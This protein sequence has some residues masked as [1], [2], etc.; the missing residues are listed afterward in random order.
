MLRLLL[1][2]CLIAADRHCGSRQGPLIARSGCGGWRLNNNIFMRWCFACSFFGHV[3]RGSSTLLV[4]HVLLIFL[5][6]TD[7]LLTPDDLIVVLQSSLHEIQPS[8]LPSPLTSIYAWVQ[9]V[10]SSVPSSNQSLLAVWRSCRIRHQCVM[11]LQNWSRL[12]RLLL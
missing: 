12:Q 7:T 11:T 10:Q 8:H 9:V 6:H 4:P 1:A 3:P 2:P 5:A